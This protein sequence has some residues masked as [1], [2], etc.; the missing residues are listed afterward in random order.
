MEVYYTQRNIYI[1][2][3]GGNVSHICRIIYLH[4]TCYAF[5]L[6]PLLLTEFSWWLIKHIQISALGDVSRLM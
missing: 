4:V 3:A 2:T 1:C 6:F 5:H